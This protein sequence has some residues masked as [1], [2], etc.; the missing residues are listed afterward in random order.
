MG[1]TPGTG[2]AAA[3]KRARPTV[4]LLAA[5]LLVGV[6]AGAAPAS[7]A[8]DPPKPLTSRR[9]FDQ[10]RPGVELITVQFSA[11][12]VV[13][14]A[15]VTE[16]NGR[17]LQ[18][19][20]ADKIRRGEIPA[21]QAAASSAIIDEMARDP[22]RWL[23]ASSRVH[24]TKVKLTATGSGFS[25]A[26]DGYIVT[27]AHVVAPKDDDIKAA[28][29]AQDIRDE[30]D[31]FVANFRQDGLSQSQ[32]TRF[33]SAIVRWAT[34]KA[35]L[36]NYKRT[37]SVLGS[38]GSG[39][40]SSSKRRAAKLVDAG[41]EFPG[42]DVAL[43]KIKSRNMATVQLGD[44]TALSTGDRLFVL[45]FPGAATFNPAL[46]K[47]SRDEPTLT[48]GVLSAKKQVNGGYTV[49]Q[50][51][52]GMTHGNSGGPVFDEQG[53]VVGVATLGSVDPNTGREVSGLNFAVPASIVNELLRRAHVTASEGPAGSAY[54]EAL[55]AFD[56]QWY[57]RSLPLLE[58][59]K[60]LDP[61]H[62]LAAKLI[63]DSQ[64]AIRQG[65][66]RTPREILGVPVLVFAGLAG[67][68]V[69]AMACVGLLAVRS[70]RRRRR[71]HRPHYS[72]AFEPAPQAPG[73]GNGWG[74]A[75]QAA[76]SGNDWG[77]AQQAAARPLGYGT[78]SAT[79]QN[80]QW[81]QDLPQ[82]PV[83]P[84]APAAPAVPAAEDAYGS[85]YGYGGNG[86]RPSQ[87]MPPQPAS[88]APQAWWGAEEAETTEFPAT[89]GVDPLGPVE[90]EPA[91]FPDHQQPLVQ[92][93]PAPPPAGSRTCSSCGQRN[94]PSLRY[95]ETCW[96]VLD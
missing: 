43:V 10:S 31:D 72:P 79:D 20:A 96:T 61:G 2:P 4:V 55:D 54:R 89:G 63:K 51:D 53:R 44:D 34:R 62:P 88:A 37:I 71:Q 69:V 32:A 56:K 57:K 29:I 77:V 67:A 36:A 39:A 22:F 52:A 73:S 14:E 42:K 93:R 80:G 60:A 68:V 5:L 19:M 15:V 24:R 12:L 87:P 64:T 78:P 7:A 38:T 27:N 21:T 30:G 75:Q 81:W 25:I 1:Q 45:G 17:A 23:T 13:P 50:T 65:R 6:V 48:Q 86:N 47:E 49:L 46:S 76:G 11:A 85:A 41:E 58:Q 35:T 66:D 40:S 90:V 74:V 18:S 59:V 94:H 82:Q 92:S 8:G 91:A 84:A 95:C 83:P 70:R 3:G 26:P 16:S 9:L 28:F 33:L